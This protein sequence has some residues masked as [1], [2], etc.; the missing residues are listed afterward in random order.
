MRW[1]LAR[2][3]RAAGQ[4][5][6]AA[7]QLRLASERQPVRIDLRLE[8]GALLCALGR[9]AEAATVYQEALARIRH[10]DTR[11]DVQKRIGSCRDRSN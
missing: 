9:S 4:I 1:E 8:L 11:R 5:E 10:E 6:E 3:L 7:Q 2:R